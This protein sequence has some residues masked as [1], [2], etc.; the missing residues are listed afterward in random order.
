M[1]NPRVMVLILPWNALLIQASALST[2]FH[3]FGGMHALHAFPRS[4]VSIEHVFDFRLV[5]SDL[6]RPSLMYRQAPW[7]FAICM[8]SV[9]SNTNLEVQVDLLVFLLLSVLPL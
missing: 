9:F 2:H 3:G 1:A 8:F 5:D 4:K 7:V 6:S